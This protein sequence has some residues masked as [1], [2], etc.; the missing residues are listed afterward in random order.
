MVEEFCKAVV[1]H[2]QGEKKDMD[3]AVFGAF[4]SN[5]VGFLIVR[6]VLLLHI[7]RTLLLL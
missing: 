4:D 6:C 3:V 1:E 7:K 2:K 5:L